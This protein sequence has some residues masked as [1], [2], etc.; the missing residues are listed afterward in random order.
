MRGVDHLVVLRQAADGLAELLLL[1][2]V[3]AQ[4]RLVE[5]QDGVLEV[6][7]RLGLKHDE[8]RD[9]PTEAL[10]PLVELDF[11]TEVVDDDDLEVLPVRDQPQL[12][13]LVAPHLTN[14]GGELDACGVEAVL[15]VVELLLV[16]MHSGLVLL[17]GGAAV[18]GWLG[19]ADCEIGELL[20]GEPQ[21]LQ[22]AQVAE[23]VL[24]VQVTGRLT[25]REGGEVDPGTHREVRRV[26]DEQG[27][28]FEQSL[29]GCGHDGVAADLPLE[30]LESRD[31]LGLVLVYQ[32][33]RGLQPVRELLSEGRAHRPRGGYAGG[34][35][36]E[37]LDDALTV[38]LLR[39]VGAE[40]G[41]VVLDL[42]V[43]GAQAGAA[44]VVVQAVV[45]VAKDRELRDVGQPGGGLEN[46]LLHLGV[47]RP[48]VV[49][50]GGELVGVLRGVDLLECLQQC[51]FSRLVDPDEQ[52]LRRLDLDLAAIVD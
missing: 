20:S 26:V 24:L 47:P 28:A 37:D 19:L 9:E 15:P 3:E 17:A 51:G 29:A 25:L 36:V 43:G 34:D 44:E 1:Q 10:A 39:E 14:R 45:E 27:D 32:R 18:L 31:F 40:T 7:L 12:D 22:Q 50:Q 4:P 16:S 8:E 30:A 33:Q 42:P 6:S 11:D 5:Q 13:P 23:V 46:C 2:R 38:V 41:E 35:R 48:G 49:A 21:Q 52:G